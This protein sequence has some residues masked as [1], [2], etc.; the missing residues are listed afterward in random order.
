MR[1]VFSKGRRP[2]H[3]F[4][5]LE[6]PDLVVVGGQVVYHAFGMLEGRGFLGGLSFDV[7][8]QTRDLFSRF[9]GSQ[10]DGP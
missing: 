9:I 5:V 8:D 3:G 6:L 2:L 1:S 7:I 4:D 10:F